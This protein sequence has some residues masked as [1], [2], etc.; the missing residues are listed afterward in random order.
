M[1]CC[2]TGPSWRNQAVAQPHVRMASQSSPDMR[3]A[4]LHT[5]CCQ[6]ALSSVW[7]A[8]VTFRTPPQKCF[9]TSWHSRGADAKR[10]SSV[11]CRPALLVDE[12]ALAGSVGGCNAW[13][14]PCNGEDALHV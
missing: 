8:L 1:S 14:L 2:D 11:V 10:S 6:M 3:R 12:V 13:S 4:T 5:I 7:E 9:S